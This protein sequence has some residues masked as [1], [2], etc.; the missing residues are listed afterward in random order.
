MD[1]FRLDDASGALYHFFWDELCD[2]YLEL[3]KPVFQSAPDALKIETRD[4]LAHCVQ[5]VLRALHP[6]IPFI[7]EELWHRV[8]R[9][10]DAHATIA[11]ATYP[12]AGDGRLDEAA[13]AQM[14][15]VQDVIVAARTIRAEHEVHPGAEIPLILRSRDAQARAVLERE[16]IGIRTLVK[17]QGDPIFAEA[18]AARPRA[19]VLAVAGPVEVLVGL[20]GLVD[21]PRERDRVDRE[22]KKAHKD[23]AAIDKKL[24]LPSFVEKAPPNVV[25]EARQNREALALKLEQLNEAM[26]LAEELAAGDSIPPGK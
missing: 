9:P 23:L 8:P 18:G 24:G 7:T 5:T 1:E 16:A 2:W 20:K 3:T 11:L 21:A 13:E 22:V 26:K 6:F 17:T 12:T 14:R 19:S 15:L 25:E 4:V 10:S